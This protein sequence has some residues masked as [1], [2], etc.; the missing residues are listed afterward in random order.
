MCAFSCDNV[1]TISD[2]EPV[3]HEGR[4][5]TLAAVFGESSDDSSDDSSDGESDVSSFLG[6]MPS[7]PCRVSVPSWP[8]LP[9]LLCPPITIGAH[10]PILGSCASRIVP[11]CHLI[12]GCFPTLYRAKQKK[13]KKKGKAP[14]KQKKDKPKKEKKTKEAEDR[15]ADTSDWGKM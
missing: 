5:E 7:F 13:K 11:L 8:C 1:A 14:A 12:V 3:V 6:L 2:A 10:G 9:L 15:P 4:R